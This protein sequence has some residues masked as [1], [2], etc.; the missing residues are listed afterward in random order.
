MPGNASCLFVSWL[1][2]LRNK[3]I[4]YMVMVSYTIKLLGQQK[5]EKIY[6]LQPWYC[7]LPFYL[8][9][10]PNSFVLKMS[11]QINYFLLSSWNLKSVHL[12]IAY[13]FEKTMDVF[14]I[15][16]WK[17]PQSIH[18][19]DSCFDKKLFS[20]SQTLWRSIAGKVWFVWLAK[21]IHP[22]NIT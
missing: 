14:L 6:R 8:R 20:L 18:I 7:T 9:D 17:K 3:T 1:D 15:H 10:Q 11:N 13:L 19:I 21:T 12:S 22:V 16:P 4:A 2:A 5:K